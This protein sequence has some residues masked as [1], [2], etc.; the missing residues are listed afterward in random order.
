[1]R[2]SDVEGFTESQLAGGA[3]LQ[4]EERGRGGGR[5][6]AATCFGGRAELV[7]EGGREEGQGGRLVSDCVWGE[8]E[9][10]REGIVLVMR[11]DEEEGWC[12]INAEYINTLAKSGWLEPSTNTRHLQE[13]TGM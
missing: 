12:K 6:W 1:M 11:D 13:K 2:R 5:S 10:G 8:G 7:L 9:G 3:T 4:G